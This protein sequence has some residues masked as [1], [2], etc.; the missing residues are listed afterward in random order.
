MANYTVAG[1]NTMPYTGG[2]Q[3]AQSDWREPEPEWARDA[4]MVATGDT[5]GTAGFSSSSTAEY[6]NAAY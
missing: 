5:D 1:M 6:S 4:T 3:F 2:Q